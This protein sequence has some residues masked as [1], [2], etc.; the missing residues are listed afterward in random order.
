[1]KRHPVLI[2]FSRFHRSCLFLALIAKK[3]APAIKG[4]PTNHSE[5]ISFTLAF[6]EN[7][8]SHHF[9]I[10]ERIWAF[11]E[12]A[13]ARLTLLVKELKDDRQELH[14]SFHLLEMEPT[15]ENLNHLGH[16]LEK[17]VRKEER[18]LFQVMQAELTEEQ[19]QAISSLAE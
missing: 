12:K 8:L 18:Q 15:T 7:E 16:L 1:M 14:E 2:P 19:M 17:H 4:Y 6:Y 13:S 9:E 3:N 5:K 11:A 10:E